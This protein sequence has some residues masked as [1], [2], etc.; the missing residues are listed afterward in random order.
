[1]VHV[2]ADAFFASVEQAG[3]TRLRGKPVAVGGEK[4][5]IIASAS[6][7]ARAFGV[8]SPMPTARARRIC[9]GLIL[10][11]GDYEKYEQFSK[12]M[13]SYAYDFTP[14]VEIC[15]IDEGYLDLRHARKSAFDIAETLRRAI[16]QSLKISVSEG[17]AS[18]KLVSQIASKLKKPDAFIYV[19]DGEE[20]R[21]L[22][23]LANRC[24]P[25]IGPQTAKRLDAA[26]LTAIGQIA[27]TPADL[28][29]MLVGS[30]APTLKEL[31]NGIDPRPLVRAAP[32]AKSY[33]HQHTYEEDVTDLDLILKTL[34]RMVD[35]LMQQVRGAKHL[36]RSL[37]VK[38]R[39]ND[40]ANDQHS[41]TLAEPTDLETDLYPRIRILLNIAWRRRV[42]LRAVTLRVAKVYTGYRPAELPLYPEQLNR[43]AHRKLAE[44]IDHLHKELGRK[45]IVRGYRVK[46][47]PRAGG[48]VPLQ[49]DPTHEI[50]TKSIR[51]GRDSA[52]YPKAQETNKIG[53]PV[54]W[55]PKPHPAAPIS[56]TPLNIHSVYSFL[57]STLTLKDLIERAKKLG[58]TSI[59][60]TDTRNLHGSVHFMK[61]ARA[62]G[63]TP[64]LG[65]E[66]EL[67]G[68]PLLVY[69]RNRRGYR[70]LCRLL[71]RFNGKLLQ[72][73]L[74]PIHGLIAVGASPDAAPL[75]P[76]GYYLGAGSP[77][78]AKKIQ[79]QGLPVVAVPRIHYATPGDRTHYDLVQSIRTLSLLGHPHP[80]KRPKKAYHFRTPKQMARAFADTPEALLNTGRIADACQF[81][82]E[83][84]KIQFPDY[85]PPD[86]SSPRAFLRSRV[87]AGIHTR[88]PDPAQHAR[89]QTQ[90][91]RELG[92]IAE[93]GYEAYFLIVW[94]LLQDC[95]ARNIHWIT[96]GSA[97][98][99][100]VCYCLGISNIC[101]LRFD[102]YFQRFL[103]PAR[104][105]MNKL[106][107]IDID[108]PHDEKDEV[109]ELI[110]QKYGPEH[111]AV[112]G[113]FSTYRSRS[114]LADIAKVLGVSE[115]QVRQLTK[116]IPH[117][118]ARH[119]QN[120]VADTPRCRD[121]PVDEEP[122]ATAL[123]TAARMAEF[124]RYAKMHPC[125]IV[126]SRAPMDT[127]TP[128][129]TSRKG[130]P[131]THLDM[132]AVEAIGLVKLD[133]L[134]QGG[135]SVMR[136]VQRAVRE[137]RREEIDLVN[138]EVKG[139]SLDS[140]LR[141][142]NPALNRGDTSAFNTQPST[143]DVRHLHLPA[144]PASFDD[145]GVWD[146]I[147]SGHARAV[148]HIESPAMIGLAQMCDVR[149]IDTLVAMVSVIRPG[150]ANQKKKLHFTRRCQGLEAPVYP[151]SA[152]ERS[153]R[154]TYGIM[155]Y[156][157]QVLQICADFAGMD[158]G[159]ADTLR[160]ALV[161]ADWARIYSFGHR[162]HAEAR[163]AGRSDEEIRT[164][165]DH[166]CGF[167]GYAFC[168]A[169]GAAYGVEAYQSA[170]LKLHY[171][172][173]FMAAV[174][175]QGKG[176]YQPL[177]YVLECHRLGLH[178]TPPCVNDPGPGFHATGRAIRVPVASILHLTGQTQKRIL[179]ARKKSPFKTLDDFFLRVYPQAE[180][181]DLLLRVG[182]LD[183]FGTSRTELFWQTRWL[184][185]AHPKQDFG[186][187]GEHSGILPLADHTP[188]SPEISLTEPT[189][190]DRLK[191]ETELLGYPVSEHPLA[192]YDTI[193]WES[194][195]RIE[196]LHRFRGRRV[197][198]CG[199]VIQE[200]MAQ[201]ANG[202]A[203][204]FMSIADWSGIIE[205]EL[206]AGTCK[207]Y[208]L[209]T[210]RH[211]VL[212]ITATVE[213]F[214]NGRGHSLR[215]H[216]V[217][218][219]RKKQPRP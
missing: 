99:S 190:A 95:R 64:V 109:F 171:P 140:G 150:A 218:E 96:R 48:S 23:P 186:A 42:S 174:L 36:I 24:I 45:V 126:L 105:K 98:D 97:A 111:A 162:F 154:S 25:G 2:D 153:L 200:R 1:M 148:H 100:L 3:D 194:Y 180:E 193:D 70:S 112:V 46:A 118:H 151:H 40:F 124:P 189:R 149:D 152:T 6:Y 116:A 195:C 142:Q 16:R 39:Y 65:A 188:R 183:G 165:W 89:I 79:G 33:S 120:V 192:L 43:I 131:T 83:Y 141:I 71:T 203:M 121:L 75:F 136:D 90:V 59:A 37:C 201:Q 9:P 32:A 87:Q 184:L 206:F 38:V 185:G 86:G 170:W 147:A 137:D 157:E 119:I 215:V 175:T 168:K 78:A 102:L 53:R 143:F 54:P 81:D 199:L 216:A 10:I 21:F 49:K 56:Y 35:D 77:A 34:F 58:C 181:F 103:N 134:A 208:G 22:A 52:P 110:L 101:P 28:L 130:W 202:E 198:C 156:E 172:A 204:K 155:V 69:V 113:G 62:A 4:R 107:D 127:L 50:H 27:N 211:P 14:D 66:L 205:T 191:A 219:P 92:I 94:D 5:G 158:P 47:S 73:T 82:F 67:N 115:Y 164:V 122:Y 177:V 161:K 210:A 133:I 26:G 17:L 187:V 207:R 15:S 13:F 74:N 61:A 209:T 72:S 166:L 135:L 214:E 217:K 176:F 128:C 146:L 51:P 138:L 80:D 63:L 85:Q 144:T 76:D 55:P 7:E 182:A 18:N 114:A 213:A 60:L 8:Y 173:E 93:V 29:S 179:Q 212:E 104:M 159:E 91:T 88:Y 106:P 145:A 139:R 125:G 68:K 12:W 129:F 178:L 31:A 19:P 30:W 123:N 41:E 163:K 117:A 44:T 169:H 167:V 84:G 132:D 108:F 20:R 57:D 197:R 11:P 160:R 196:D